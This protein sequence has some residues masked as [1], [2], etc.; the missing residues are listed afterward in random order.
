MKNWEGSLNK[1]LIEAA[2]AVMNP[3]CVRL[4]SV[5][6]GPNMNI[7]GSRDSN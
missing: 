2:A 3:L 7:R 4:A 6:N 1:R 5:K